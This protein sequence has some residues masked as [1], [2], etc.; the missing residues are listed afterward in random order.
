MA[1]VKLRGPMTTQPQAGTVDQVGRRLIPIKWWAVCGAA[2]LIVQLWIYGAWLTSGDLKRTPTGPTPV[3]E[4]SKISIQVVEVVGVPA[5]L[6]FLY[7]LVVRPWVRQGKPS[8]NGLLCLAFFTIIWQDPLLNY[9]QIHFTYN[10]YATQFGSWAGHIPGFGPHDGSSY[11]QPLFFSFCGYIYWILGIT[12]LGPWVMR[13]A[14]LRWPRLGKFGLLAIC[15]VFTGTVESVAEVVVMGPTKLFAYPGSIEWLTVFHGRT[16]QFPIYE[17]LFSGLLFTLFGALIYFRDDKG[18]TFAERG[19]DSLRVTHR[20]RTGLRF[21][22]LSGAL[23]VMFLIAY[24]IPMQW[25]GTHSDAWPKSITDR[26]YLT[27]YQC[28][29]DTHYACPGTG[30]PHRQA[31]LTPRQSRRKAG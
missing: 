20:Q 12:L 6:A 11:P 31:E 30:Y 4:F 9:S 1:S 16:Y 28:G 10:S 7:F 3:P 13:R 5:L 14:K 27:V 22:A 18:Q 19:L 2:C 15:L 21:L 8:F 26:S 24:N 25:P 23:N 17:W 29:L